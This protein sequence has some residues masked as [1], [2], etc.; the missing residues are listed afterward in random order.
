MLVSMKSRGS[1][2]DHLPSQIEDDEQDDDCWCVAKGDHMF[3]FDLKS[4]NQRQDDL[5]PVKTDET[6]QVGDDDLMFQFDL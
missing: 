2:D 4:S 1:Q 6:A 5:K 3:R